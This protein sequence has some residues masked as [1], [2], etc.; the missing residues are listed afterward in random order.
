MTM[1]RIVSRRRK[2]QIP[3]SMAAILVEKAGGSAEPGYTHD[4]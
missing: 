1:P 3:I 2:K 4:V